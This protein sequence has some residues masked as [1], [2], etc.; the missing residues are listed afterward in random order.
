[1]V[2]KS[3]RSSSVEHT[4]RLIRETSPYLLQH[5]HNPVDWYPWGEDAFKRAREDD[6]PI[7]LSVG[8]AAC[9]WCHVMEKESFEDPAVADILN[10]HFV[11]LKVDREEHPD[12]DEIYMTAVQMMTGSGG[13][14]MSVFLTTDLKPFYGGTYFPPSDRM[15]LP[16]FS[17]VLLR[18][19]E[20]WKE[21]RG[22]VTN[23]ASRFVEALQLQTSPAPA[24]PSNA[25][26]IALLDG[27][28][29][30][31]Q[32]AFD[33]VHGGFGG[34][35]KFP[36][37]AAIRLLLRQHVR[38]GGAACLDM[39]TSTLDR[40]ADGGIYDQIGGGFHRYS[41]DSRWLVPHF[42]KMLY[43]NAQ[44]ATA[45]L[46]AFQVAQRPSY[47]RI[48]SETLDYVL[49]DMSAPEGGFCS[50][51]DADS[52]GDEGR[53]Y[54]WTPAEI[55]AVLGKAEARLFEAYYGVTTSGNFEGRNILHV[56]RG[57]GGASADAGADTRPDRW[58]ER[59]RA[60]RDRR[61]RPARDDKV[62]ASWNGLMIGALADGYRVLGEDRYRAAA[63]AAAEFVLSRLRAEDGSLLRVFRNGK[64]GQPAFLDDHANMANALIDLYEATFEIR[65]LQTADDLVRRLD[66]Q[67]W[68]EKAGCYAATGAAHRHLIVRTRPVFDGVEPSGNS[69]AALALL[70]LGRL[71]GRSEYAARAERV[72]QSLAGPMGETPQGFSSMLAAVA[73]HLAPDMEVAIIGG[74]DKADTRELLGVIHGRFLPN[75]AV[76]ALDPSSTDAEQS[77]ALVPWLA[78]RPMVAGK[79]TAYVCR[80]FTC[81]APVTTAADLAQLLD[82]AS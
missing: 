3:S 4:N 8:Y 74:A 22:E 26:P 69:A 54:V 23:S 82:P 10:R 19:A 32:A 53:F 6:K 29:S 47:R 70:R 35:P 76:A 43:D 13:W 16:A 5:A 25:L 30:R 34:A 21:K 78:D 14:P 24:A 40:M 72:M 55:E 27:A 59:M 77:L 73:F 11:S 7:F 50:S 31:L 28:V 36:P 17:N 20:V 1:M 45:C 48:A 44:L 49:R 60:A 75:A 39:A 46:E 15:G 68:D 37:S 9:H 38:T 61:A 57:A 12:V 58:R 67:F 2:W 71:T 80:G 52:E 62:I 79:A 33:G 64:A 18:I 65:W 41:T 56:A 51:E 66:R 42:E 81:Q 63:R